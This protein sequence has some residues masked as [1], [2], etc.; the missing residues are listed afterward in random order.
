[1]KK[2]KFFKS[3]TSRK[4]K[5]FAMFLNLEQFENIGFF[6]DNFIYLEEIDLCKRLRK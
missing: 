2:W 5:R 4:C 6:D 1:M 3:K